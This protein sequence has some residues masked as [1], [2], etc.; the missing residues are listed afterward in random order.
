MKKTSSISKSKLKNKRFQII[1]GVIYSDQS[2][3]KDGIG[4]CYFEEDIKSA[5]LFLKKEFDYLKKYETQDVHKLIMEKINQAF[6]DVI[7]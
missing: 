5:I 2:N 1:D 3:F 4:F 6:R 7:E